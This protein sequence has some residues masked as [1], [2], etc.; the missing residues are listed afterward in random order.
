MGILI[1]LMTVLCL[2]W[3]FLAFVSIPIGMVTLEDTAL[4]IEQEHQ[5]ACEEN[6][7]KLGLENATAIHNEDVATF[8]SVWQCYCGTQKLG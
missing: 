3:L 8:E 6:C 2:L 7:G 1:D 5:L 4:Q